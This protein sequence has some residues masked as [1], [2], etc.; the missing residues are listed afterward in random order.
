[1]SSYTLTH[2]SSTVEHS[3][4]IN[5]TSISSN[6]S[7]NEPQQV[8]PQKTS[9]QSQRNRRTKHAKRIRFTA[10]REFQEEPRL[11]KAARDT[12]KAGSDAQRTR[13][14]APSQ[15]AEQASEN[16]DESAFEL[17]DTDWP[18]DPDLLDFSDHEWENDEPNEESDIVYFRGGFAKFDEPEELSAEA[19]YWDYQYSR[20]ETD[21]GDKMNEM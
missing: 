12:S 5:D 15:N 1:M 7:S 3:T 4:A 21:G 19:K 9:S 20:D 18:E 13:D 14:A 8:T 10:V 2:T 16:D 17:Q 6:S 11:K